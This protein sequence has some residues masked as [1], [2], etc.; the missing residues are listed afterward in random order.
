MDT[1]NTILVSIAIVA[2]IVFAIEKTVLDYFRY[3]NSRKNKAKIDELMNIAA[4]TLGTLVSQQLNDSVEAEIRKEVDKSKFIANHRRFLLERNI[5]KAI[6]LAFMDSHKYSSYAETSELSCTFVYDIYGIFK[7][8]EADLDKI[9]VVV[10]NSSGLCISERIKKR[11][12]L[13]DA[14]KNE[15]VFTDVELELFDAEPVRF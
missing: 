10:W 4:S 8:V 1:T 15:A 12:I 14:N 11:G 13:T 9:V 2:I 3:R 6:T 7:H 5:K